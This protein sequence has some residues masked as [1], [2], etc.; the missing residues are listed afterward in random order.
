[1]DLKKLLAPRTIAIVGASEK[2][3]FGGDTCRN[4]LDY[5]SGEGVYFINPKRDEVFGKKCLPSLVEIPEAIDL[6]VICTPQ[7]TVEMILRQAHDKGARAAVVYAS[8]YSEVGTEEGRKAEEDLKAL[9]SELDIALM[10]PNCAGFM[11][12]TDGVSAFAFIS[13]KRDRKGSVGIVSQSGQLC[14]S[15]MD[16]PNMRFSY[17]ISSGNSSVVS[18]EDY[19]D[20]L[21]EDESTKVVGLYLEGVS[22]PAK[23]MACL[24]KAALARKPVVVLKAGRSEKGSRIAASHTGSLSGA[25]RIYDAIFEKFGVIR[26]NDLEEL[27]ATTVLFST[28]P[29]LPRQSGFASMNLSGGETGMCADMGEAYGIDY[30]DFAEETLNKLRELLPD[31]ASPANPLDSTATISYDADTYAATLQAVMDDPKVGMLVIGYTLLLDIA[32]PAIHYM[33]EGIEKVVKGGKAKPMAMLPFVENTRNPEY[34]DKLTRLGV[35][36]LPPPAYAFSVLGHL[37]RFIEYDPS[38]HTLEAAVPTA[39]A[40]GER[41]TLSEYESMQMLSKYDIPLPKG[42]LAAT[43]DEAAELADECGYPVVLKVASAD[44]GHKSDMGGVKLHLEDSVAVRVAFDEI[45]H[46]ARLNAPDARVDGVF[47]QRMLEPGQEVIIGVSK[48]PQFGPS[49]LCGLGGIFVEVFKDTALLPAPVT[50]DEA[51]AMI[52]SLKSLPLFTGYRGAK[53]LD[54]DAL[55]ELIERVSRFA[56]EHRDELEELDLNPV[57]VYE[58]GKGVCAADALVVLSK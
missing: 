52:R 46:N 34:L 53:P 31:Y 21:I 3:G 32:D 57:F 51:R 48:D 24:K 49:I 33:A 2:E 10:G 56:A 25:D 17:S 12:Y 7:K 11:N 26:V 13:E 27:L 35:P 19:L 14:L 38:A 20:Y 44:I 37:K 8:G 23:F 18:M 15:L 55:A 29:E 54:M 50:R 43:H 41:R 28:L 45:M 16:S 30:P 40:S 6:V 5:S 47:I 36:V 22:Q 39:Q 9:C 4:V 58:D 1:M 42:G